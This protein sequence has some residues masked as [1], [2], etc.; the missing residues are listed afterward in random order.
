[1]VRHTYLEVTSR[2]RHCV[3]FE[4][5]YLPGRGVAF[6][7]I[8]CLVHTNQGR[9][10][11]SCIVSHVCFMCIA[12]FLISGVQVCNDTIVVVFLHLC[13]LLWPESLK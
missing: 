11:Y 1:M 13:Q 4:E 12:Y 2:V 5:I 8:G 3:F 7:Q 9:R 6:G 10:S